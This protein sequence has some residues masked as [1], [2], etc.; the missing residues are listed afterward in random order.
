MAEAFR[1]TFFQKVDSKARVSIPAA[2]R[3]VLEA[4]DPLSAENT[5][6]R[7]YMVYGGE[8]RNFVECYTR[9]GA[10]ALAEAIDQ[11]DWG[12]DERAQTEFE[13]IEQ[14]HQ[15]EIEP[16]GRIVLPLDIRTKMGLST[17]DLAQGAEA[18]FVG[19]INRFK[20][21]SRAVYEARR[22]A[23]PSDGLDP[24]RRISLALKG[25]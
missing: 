6:P 1:G 18:V 11:M 12:S 8:T 2:M 3:R 7:I 23:M 17:Q 10:D 19:S 16:D 24:L 21:Y 9:K 25:Q 14:S 22:A 5:R 15:A 20:L 13:M 4:E